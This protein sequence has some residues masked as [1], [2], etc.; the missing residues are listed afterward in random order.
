MNFGDLAFVAARSLKLLHVNETYWGNL[1]VFNVTNTIEDSDQL[2][3]QLCIF[4]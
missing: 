1:V 4:T 2:E 3:R